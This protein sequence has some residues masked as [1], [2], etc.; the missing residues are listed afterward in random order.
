MR[1]G[2]AAP[3]LIQMAANTVYEPPRLIVLGSVSALTLG[4]GND[5]CR[6]NPPRDTDKQTGLADLI[7]G[8]ASLV[9]CSA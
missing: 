8:Q 1:P 7:L 4:D 6:L 9:T 2:A 5:P 3:T